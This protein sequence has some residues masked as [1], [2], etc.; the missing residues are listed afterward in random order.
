MARQ[1]TQSG[2]CGWDY[3]RVLVRKGQRLQ[4]SFDKPV[5]SKN[6]YL[7]PSIKALDE[8]LSVQENMWGSLYGKVEDLRIGEDYQ[9]NIDQLVDSLIKTVEACHG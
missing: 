5:K 1:T 4:A 7:E 9:M 8:A 3:A 6:G 2:S